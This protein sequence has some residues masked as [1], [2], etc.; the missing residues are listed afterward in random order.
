MNEAVYTG[1]QF[2]I[3]LKK[4][5]NDNRPTEYDKLLGYTIYGGNELINELGFTPKV[6]KPIKRASNK[7]NTTVVILQDNGSI[8]WFG[9]KNGE[10]ANTCIEIEAR[11]N[12][13]RAKMQ[14]TQYSSPASRNKRIAY[15]LDGGI[16]GSLV[17]PLSEYEDVWKFFT[18]ECN[19]IVTPR[20]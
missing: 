20:K 17:I 19:L 14:L 8:Y 5:V 3:D 16:F 9:P 1:K 18:N 4:I 11:F 15:E 6:T 7:A 13:R 12:V 10:L 2:V